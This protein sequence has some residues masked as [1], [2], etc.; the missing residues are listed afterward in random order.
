[1]D[2]VSNDFIDFRTIMID[3]RKEHGWN[4]A[5]LARR[6]DMTESAISYIESGKKTP[7]FI[8]MQKISNAFGKDISELLKYKRSN[9]EINVK[10]R[11]ELIDWALDPAN[12]PYLEFV[13]KLSKEV[14]PDELQNLK[15][16]KELV[17]GGKN[18]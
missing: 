13:Y 8:S 5:E 7:N 1:L 4:Q 12:K 3:L 11:S 14:R 17:I 2:S 16:S 10:S 18:I 9:V 6:S 15:I